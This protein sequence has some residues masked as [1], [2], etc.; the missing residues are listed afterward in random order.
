MKNLWYPNPSAKSHQ[1]KGL[2]WETSAI[3]F[4]V[5]VKLDTNAAGMTAAINSQVPYIIQ[6]TS[7]TDA[8]VLGIITPCYILL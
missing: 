5:P 2:C 8:G 3:N 4:G 1:N 6:C 7:E